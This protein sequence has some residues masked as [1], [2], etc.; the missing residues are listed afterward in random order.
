MFFLDFFF[1]AY[2]WCAIFAQLSPLDTLC[3]DGR[4][5][6][7]D[8]AFRCGSLVSLAL[9]FARSASIPDCK[10]YARWKHGSVVFL[11]RRLLESFVHMYL[12]A[13]FCVE[14]QICSFM[15]QRWILCH[16]FSPPSALRDPT[17]GAGFLLFITAQLMRTQ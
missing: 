6:R 10:G 11:P 12:R 1:I 15:F 13:Y 16:S 14:R 5:R 2:N 8:I 7:I 3:R 9:L 4:R 17:V